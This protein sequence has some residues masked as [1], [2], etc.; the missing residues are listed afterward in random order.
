[1]KNSKLIV[2]ILFLSLAF[3]KI[4]TVN[5]VSAANCS[6]TS[7]VK[8]QN[9]K[10][11]KKYYDKKCNVVKKE[12]KY[13]KQK[14]IIKYTYFKN[15]K[16]KTIN[17]IKYFKSSK[18]KYREINIKYS[19]ETLDKNNKFRFKKYERKIYFNKA[20]QKTSYKKYVKSF[21]RGENINILTIKYKN[22]LIATKSKKEYIVEKNKKKIILHDFYKYKMIENKNKKY[23]R[24]YTS[25]DSNVKSW[26]INFHY[27]NLVE[28]TKKYNSK[29]ELKSNKN[30]DA[31]LEKKDGNK[32]LNYYYKYD[33]NGNL[34]LVETKKID[35][36]TWSLIIPL[37]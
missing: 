24:S 11:I 19:Y 4:N 28:Y 10:I 17:S 7:I 33:E 23:Y 30:G 15:N 2:F 8:Q 32:M 14:T 1:M 22:G 18:K 21:F 36:F 37:T 13:K 5:E 25:Y 16:V 12:I 31:Y 26:K 20:G 34:N 29:G 35:E 27:D 9:G 3:L 6:K